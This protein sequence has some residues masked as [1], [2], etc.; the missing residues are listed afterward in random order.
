MMQKKVNKVLAQLIEQL[1]PARTS[2]GE[3]EKICK[4][5]K[6]S[7]ST[8][9]TARFRQG[10]SADTLIKLLLAHGVSPDILIN[11]PRTRPSQISKSLTLW[12]KI[13]LNLTEG[14]GKNWESLSP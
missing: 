14:S 3:R 5:T 11:L 7:H 10:M 8:L 4:V 1:V 2:K 9:R 13:G 6:L 12:N